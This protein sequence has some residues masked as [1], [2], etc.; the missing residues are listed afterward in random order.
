M[1][2]IKCSFMEV[3]VIQVIFCLQAFLT[4]EAT[5]GSMLAD[6]CGSS[7]GVFL[8]P[9]QH[10][11]QAWQDSATNSSLLLSLTVAVQNENFP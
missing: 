1:T 11:D 5:G 2:K 8:L 7:P 3:S 10:L 4:N 6:A 9:H